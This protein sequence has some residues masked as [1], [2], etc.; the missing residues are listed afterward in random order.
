MIGKLIETA[1]A[2]RLRDVTEIYILFPDFQ[3]GIQFNRFTKIVLEF[4]TE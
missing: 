1:T 3:I 2:K 4:F